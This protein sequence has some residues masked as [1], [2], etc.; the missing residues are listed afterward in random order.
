MRQFIFAAVALFGTLSADMG[1]QG[2]KAY[3]NHYFVETGSFHGGGI[4]KALEAGFPVIHSL[5]INQA[6][7]DECR[8]DFAGFPQVHV[9]RANS[10]TDLGGIISDIHSPITFWLDGHNIF[11]D[12]NGGKNSPIMEELEQIKRHEIKTHTILIDDRHVMGTAH[13]DGITEQQIIK[14]LLEINPQYTISFAVGGG[15]GEYPGNVIV[16]SVNG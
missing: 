2:F 4:R 16:A 8:R 13:F 14:K 12:P 7:V 15:S 6:F 3:P 1:P 5:E 11:V 9:W 10:G